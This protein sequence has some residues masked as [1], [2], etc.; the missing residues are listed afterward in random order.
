M[1]S[2]GS[3]HEILVQPVE[4]TLAPVFAVGFSLAFAL[5]TPAMAAAFTSWPSQ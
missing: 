1:V 3:H 2:F 5:W 4:A